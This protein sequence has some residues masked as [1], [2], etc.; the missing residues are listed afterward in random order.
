MTKKIQCSVTISRN[1][2]D[3]ITITIRD[4]ASR[5]NFVSATMTP[6]AFALAVTGLA[7]QP[8]TAEVFGLEHVGKRKI[9]EQRVAVYPGREFSK[10]ELT[11]WL[12]ENHQEE[13]CILNPRLDSQSSVQHNSDGSTTLNYSV[14][15]YIDNQDAE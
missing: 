5:I 7:E 4:Q 1:S 15:K 13:G 10:K 8:A 14:T 6:D 2:H 12:T 3:E 9:M 11:K